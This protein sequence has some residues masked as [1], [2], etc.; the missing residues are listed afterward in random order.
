MPA[1]LIPTTKAEDFATT[2]T[3]V[4]RASLKRGESAACEDA[5]SIEEHKA[6][7]ISLCGWLW[8]GFILPM[9]TTK[10]SGAKVKGKS[11][12]TMISTKAI[13]RPVAPGGARFWELLVLCNSGNL[14]YPCCCGPP[15]PEE[16]E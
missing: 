6:E 14:E 13:K 9:V 8:R 16:D 11:E 12:R 1:L 4:R 5:S 3:F 10:S 7:E 2:P 15:P